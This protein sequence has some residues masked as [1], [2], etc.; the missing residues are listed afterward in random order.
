MVS[1]FHAG[2]VIG[3]RYFVTILK[4]IEEPLVFLMALDFDLIQS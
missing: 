1:Y 3:R 2:A 4:E